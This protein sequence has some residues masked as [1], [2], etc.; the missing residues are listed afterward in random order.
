MKKAHTVRTFLAG[1]LAALFVMGIVPS[2]LAAAYKTISVFPGVSIYIDDQ[3]LDPRDV[4]GNP[5]DVFIY[6]GTT[7]LPARA[8]S[9]ALGK[10]VL[11]DGAT[12]SVYIGRHN[13]M[14]PAVWLS[15]L[16]YFSGTSDSNFYTTATEKDNTGA[17]HTYCITRSFDR[18]YLLNGQYSRL[19]GTLY[20]T[21]DERSDSIHLDNQGVYI[22]GDGELLFSKTYDKD[23]TGIK[24]LSF[25]VD[26]T[27]VLELRVIF[28]DG[29]AQYNWGNMLSLGEVG[30][31]T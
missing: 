6:N 29:D 12:D 8:I 16:D 14:K 10:T 18:T 27:G 21:Y 15:Q 31:W 13:G 24:P 28:T 1:V 26:L 30:L 25:N 2:A 19:T 20:Q 3:K 9:E 7:Y 23:E 17:A 5:V 11:W 4:N 22:Y